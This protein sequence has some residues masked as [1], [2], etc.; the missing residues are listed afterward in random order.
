MYLKK[1]IVKKYT[2]TKFTRH[3]YVE[4]LETLSKEE[5]GL[6]VFYWN[7]CVNT[8]CKVSQYWVTKADIETHHFYVYSF[9][10]VEVLLFYYK[11]F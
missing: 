11:K 8:M 2:T 10:Y 1:M 5:H 7:E 9:L 6:Y 3:G 4:L